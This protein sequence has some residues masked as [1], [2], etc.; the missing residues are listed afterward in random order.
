MPPPR[1][2]LGH[3]QALRRLQ[4]HRARLQKAGVQAAQPAAPPP[5]PPPAPPNQ[6]GKD[7]TVRLG[8]RATLIA[9]VLAAVAAIL[10]PVITGLFGLATRPDAKPGGAP[11]CPAVVAGYGTQLARNPALF[12][13]LASSAAIDPDARRCGIDARTLRELAHP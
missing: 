5:T 3:E 9:G 8:A 4:A 6:A 11:A 12:D 2:P 1:Q 7:Q 10:V 13:A